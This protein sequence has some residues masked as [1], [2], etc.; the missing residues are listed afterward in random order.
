MKK[1]VI[2]ILLIMS[3]LIMV[4]NVVLL[5]EY[6]GHASDDST[7]Q[8]EISLIVIAQEVSCGNGVCDTNETCST[9]AS[10]CGSCPVTPVTPVVEGGGGGGGAAVEKD[11][12]IDP[13]LIKVVIKQ[14]E[15]FKIPVKIKNLANKEQAFEIELGKSLTDMI[16]ISETSFSLKVGEE[17]SIYITFVSNEKTEPGVYTGNI[18][19]KT[20]YKTKEIS[21]I[22]TIKSTKVLFDI[23]LDIPPKY[24]EILAGEEL[25]LQSTLFNLGEVG[26]TDVSIEYIIKDFEGNTIIQESEVVAVETQVSFSKFFKMP[27]DIKKGD[28]VAISQARYDGSLG[29]SSAIFRIV[30]KETPKLNTGMIIFIII[31]ILL[32]LII[33]LVM[34]FGIDKFK[35]LD[36]DIIDKRSYVYK[37]IEKKVELKKKLQTLEKAFSS[38][39]I[40]Q[41][42]YIRGI[43]RIKRMLDE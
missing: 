4:L 19:V 15:T 37:N 35:K 41:D 1:E 12:S 8:G 2:Y 29:S 17:K 20:P 24:K 42:S 18:K 38:G 6:T 34:K 27:S 26:K 23:S 11:F 40:S 33:I 9:C 31:I 25:L 30:E 39:Y 22:D 5:F 32:I 14:G 13:E 21:I 36:K 3:F 10:D 16:L 28:Y 7:A 43:E